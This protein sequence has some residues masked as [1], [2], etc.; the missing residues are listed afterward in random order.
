MPG[1]AQR[2]DSDFVDDEKYQNSRPDWNVGRKR[3]A[4][5]GVSIDQGD[6]RQSEEHKESGL[7][8]S[9]NRNHDTRQDLAAVVHIGS[10]GRSPAGLVPHSSPPLPF[11]LPL[12]LFRLPPPFLAGLLQIIEFLLR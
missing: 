2:R 6:D 7:D 3:P 8:D 5:N 11:P 12:L 4:Q 1:V 9:E 10:P